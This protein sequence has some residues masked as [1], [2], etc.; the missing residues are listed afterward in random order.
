M[1]A[2]EANGICIS[3][4]ER[5][6]P[7]A[8]AV[9]LLHGFGSDLRMWAASAAVF[10]RDYRV[11]APDLRGHGRTSVPTVMEKYTMEAYVEDLRCLLDALEIEICALVGCSF[12]GMIAV[13]AAITLPERFAGVVL[14][15]SS[16][17]YENA[18]YDERYRERERGIAAQEA[19]IAQHGSDGAGKRAAASVRDPFLAEGIRKRYERIHAEGFLGAARVRRERPD[20]LGVIGERLT[21][22]V[23]IC[24]G[25]EDP[26]HCASLLM[27]DQLP[28]ARV[29]TFR[30]TG[31]GIPARAPE[32]FA[33]TVVRFFSDIEEGSPLAGRRTV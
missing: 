18:G 23:L 4:E 9:V 30:G 5:G 3:Y 31:H 26:V 10:A 32:L 20:L 25:D 6:D 24:T 8:P 2:I 17:A 28:A 33:E 27:A 1:P 15:D 14:S 21:G 12:G 29:V 16:A 19:M 22:P 7:E 13:Q 11:I